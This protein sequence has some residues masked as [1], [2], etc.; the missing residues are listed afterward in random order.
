MKLATFFNQ[1]KLRNYFFPYG[2]PKLWVV[3]K[4]FERVKLWIF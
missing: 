3:L 4:P 2:I 1:S